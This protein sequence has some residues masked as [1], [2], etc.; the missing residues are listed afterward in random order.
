MNFDCPKYWESNLG[1]SPK[2]E[3]VLTLP[4]HWKVTPGIVADCY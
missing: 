4:A 3:N 2:A 1:A